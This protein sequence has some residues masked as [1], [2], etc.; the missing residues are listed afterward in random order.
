MLQEV[1]DEVSLELVCDF[2][3]GT[4]PEI[5][6]LV[7][8]EGKRLPTLHQYYKD[9]FD[10]VLLDGGSTDGSVDLARNLGVTVF[11]RHGVELMGE[12]HFVLYANTMCRSDMC[13]Y[14]FA[15]EYVGINELIRLFA[16]MRRKPIIVLGRRID[17]MFGEQVRAIAGVT[18]RLFAKGTA[19][20][21]PGNLHSSLQCALK[22]VDKLY[23]DVH[24]LHVWNGRKVFG[25][26]GSYAFS[27][28][29]QI[30]GKNLRLLRF[31][32]R[33]LIGSV[34]WFFLYGLVEFRRGPAFVIWVFLM[35]VLRATLGMLAFVEQKY[36]LSP[37][38]QLRRYLKIYEKK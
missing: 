12:N 7:L 38:D 5:V 19:R 32:K 24:H 22:D 33:F 29:E 21:D 34:S 11:R 15:D 17:W 1:P 35:G 18:P 3:G 20:Y 25:Q 13:G 16:E 36:L 31:V 30:R 2:R 9:H 27:E 6:L 37:D 23:V 28:M 26:G 4:R 8:N 14:F 10:L